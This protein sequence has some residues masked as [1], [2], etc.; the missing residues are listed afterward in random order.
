MGF[1]KNK[2]TKCEAEVK[3]ERTSE[4]AKTHRSHGEHG[5]RS[6]RWSKMEK[7]AHGLNSISVISEQTRTR[8]TSAPKKLQAQF[9]RKQREPEGEALNTWDVQARHA[10]DF[11][12]IRCRWAE[13][14][15]GWNTVKD[16]ASNDHSNGAME[17]MY[18]FHVCSVRVHL[19]VQSPCPSMHPTIPVVTSTAR[20]HR[21]HP[22]FEHTLI[23]LSIMSIPTP[24][25]RKP[26]PPC[27]TVEAMAL[28]IH[29]T[30][31]KD[32]PQHHPISLNDELANVHGWTV[33]RI[34]DR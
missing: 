26:F 13:V 19:Y 32:R 21:T 10:Q 16:K 7:Y 5:L 28:S 17:R 12:R 8:D 25:A 30:R 4:E 31:L 6:W 11:L 24:S 9:G 14:R 33:F 18:S 29:C 20:K 34:L 15:R 23:Q 22:V 3:F 27:Y 2:G 1:F